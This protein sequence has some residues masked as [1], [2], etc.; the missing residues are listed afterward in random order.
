[1]SYGLALAAKSIVMTFP[2]VVVLL[3]V[4]PLRRLS[5]GSGGKEAPAVVMETTPFLV[6]SALATLPTY[7]AQMAAS[8]LG[9]YPWPT[10]IVVAV[11]AL[12]FYLVKTLLPVNLSPLYEVPIPLNPLESRFVVSAGGVLAVSALVLALRRQWPAGLALWTFYVIALSPTLG[13]VV[14]AG[15]Q[16]A[17][18]R[19]TYVGCL[20]WALGVGAAAGVVA[21]AYQHGVIGLGLVRLAAGTALA[22]FIGLGVLTWQQVQIWRNSQTLWAHAVRVNP[23]CALCHTNLGL[24]HLAQGA[25]DAAVGHLELAVR[26]RPDRVLVR[27]DLGFALAR[28]GRLPEALAQYEAVL[29]ARPDALEARQHFAQALHQVGRRQEAVEQLRVAGVMAADD[30]GVQVNL[31]FALMR[32]GHPAEAVP[33]FHRAIELGGAAAPAHLG[34]TEAYLALGRVARAREEYEALRA[35]DPRLAARLG[36]A[37]PPDRSP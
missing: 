23:D 27:G 26:L 32:L 37:F 2:A 35:L 25:P 28:L 18:D 20:G 34:L 19:Y 9:T 15:F 4:Y 7:A 17:A 13:I 5:G 14:R 24:A 29:T 11:H 10:R 8:A 1:V 36:A 30:A 6:L 3:N 31:G 21:R 22:G 16:L 33:R 12:W